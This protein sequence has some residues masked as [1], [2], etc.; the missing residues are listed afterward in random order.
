MS[1][2]YIYDSDLFFFLME[3]KLGLFLLC[4]K[5]AAV[6]SSYKVI[7]YIFPH[8]FLLFLSC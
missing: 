6:T 3:E 2:I 5:T 1:T 7:I 8:C 4:I